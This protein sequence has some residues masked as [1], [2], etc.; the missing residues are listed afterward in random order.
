MVDNLSLSGLNPFKIKER[1][2]ELTNDLRRLKM[3]IWVIANLWGMESLNCV[4]TD[5]KRAKA[6]WRAYQETHQ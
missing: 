6:Y 1:N 4:C 5:V 3:A 2:R